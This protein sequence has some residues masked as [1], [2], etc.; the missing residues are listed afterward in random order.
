MSIRKTYR[1][2]I[3]TLSHCYYDLKY[4]FVWTPKYR[5]KVLD[6]EKTKQELTRIFTSISKWKQMEIIELSIQI[7]HVHLVILSSPTYSPSYIMQIIK[8]K[9]SSWL[10]K[11][12]RHNVKLYEKGSLWV[13]GYFVSTVGIDEII[14]R[15]YVQHQHK[16][17]QLD[18][19]TLFPTT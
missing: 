5:G 11:K 12:I 15:R 1:R 13:R 7:D 10:K 4:H 6:D 17:N 14:I 9:S 19:P 2:T 8:G 16:H 3:R 18:Q